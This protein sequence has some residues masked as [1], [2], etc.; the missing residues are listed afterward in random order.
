MNFCHGPDLSDALTA[1]ATVLLRGNVSYQAEGNGFG[2][3]FHF[4]SV[5]TV[6]TV[7]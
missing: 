1:H 6:T 7:L 3:L 2:L 5:S 4:S